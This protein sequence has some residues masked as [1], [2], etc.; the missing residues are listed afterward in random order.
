MY[1]QEAV[2]CAIDIPGHPEK[3][4]ALELG[5]PEFLSLQVDGFGRDVLPRVPC[6]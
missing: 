3:M 6:E 2:T 1:E 4:E 5:R